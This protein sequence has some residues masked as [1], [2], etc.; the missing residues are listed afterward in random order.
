MRKPE[1]TKPFNIEHAKA[2][3][4]Y[5]C[6]G[7]ASADV[8]KWDRR[9]PEYKLAGIS[10]VIGEVDALTTWTICG[11]HIRGEEESPRDLVMLPLGMIDGRPVFVND[12]FVGYVGMA[13]KAIPNLSSDFSGCTWPAPTKIYPKTM[14]SDSEIDIAYRSSIGHSYGARRAIANVAL[15]HAIESGQVVTAEQHAR[16]LRAL[17]RAGYQDRGG[18]EWAPPVGPAPKFVPVA[19]SERDIQIAN[20][21]RAWY[22]QE[23]PYVAQARNKPNLTEI[24][25]GVAS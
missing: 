4:P 6:R 9:H 12:E 8:L 10:D 15:R 2:G 1:F 23:F 5:C 24:I 20:A 7:G 25:A 13:C 19:D 21:V 16:A 14:M 17:E 11:A 22:E 3:A 18:K